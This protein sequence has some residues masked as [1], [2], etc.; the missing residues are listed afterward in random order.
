VYCFRSMCSRIPKRDDKPQRRVR[1]S[2]PSLD[3]DVEVLWRTGLLFTE[4]ALL[5]VKLRKSRC[6]GSEFGRIETKR[7]STLFDLTSRTVSLF[8]SSI[9][10]KRVMR[11]G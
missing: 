9:S 6:G 4:S 5:S 10:M 3:L 7:G 2:H 11:I 8:P 1:V